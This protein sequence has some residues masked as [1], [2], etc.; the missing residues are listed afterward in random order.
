MTEQTLFFT[1][2][3]IYHA[4]IL[5]GKPIEVTTTMLEDILTYLDRSSN[6][7]KAIFVAPDDLEENTSGQTA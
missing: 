7:K 4:N 2:A 5:D 3:R 1:L 6:D